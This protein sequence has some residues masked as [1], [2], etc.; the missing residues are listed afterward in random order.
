MRENEKGVVAVLK[1]GKGDARV[2]DAYIIPIVNV[3]FI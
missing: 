2:G 3:K 1:N